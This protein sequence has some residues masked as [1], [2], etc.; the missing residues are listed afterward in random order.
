MFERMVWL[1]ILFSVIANRV[2]VGEMPWVRVADDKHG[3]VLSD[4]AKPFVPGDSTTTTMRTAACWR[5]TGTRSGPRSR[6]T[7]GR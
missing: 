5:T 6:K 7:S 2:A 4:S 1:S 3:F